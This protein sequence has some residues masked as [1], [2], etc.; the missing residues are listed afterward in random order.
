MKGFLVFRITIMAVMALLGFAL[1]SLLETERG[2]ISILWMGSLVLA[3]ALLGLALPP[4]ALFISRSLQQVPLHNLFAAILG[5]G[6]SLLLSALF[7]VPLSLLPGA[8]GKILPV[9]TTLVFCYV[10]TFLAVQRSRE[11][12]QLF[13][14]PYKSKAMRGLSAFNGGQ[15]LVDTS[16][17]IDGRIADISRTGF[18]RGEML[19]PS[20]VLAELQHIADSSD[21]LRRRRGRRGLDMLNK[22][23]KE[24]EVPV[25]IID[26]DFEDVEG[27][28]AKLVKL[29]KSLRCPIISNDFNLNRVAELQG[30]AV[31][32]INELAMSVKPIVLP[33]E[34]M[35]IRIIQEGKEAGQGV[36]FLDDGTMVVVEGGKRYIN[37]QVEVV[38]TRVL[39]T[40]VGRMVFAQIKNGASR[41]R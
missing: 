23:Q 18:L 8:W 14:S 1:A 26:M 33:G 12:A 41:E 35:G 40:A 6:V 28:D 25:Q 24:A 15:V 11:L 22:L 34:E 36:G 38:I 5:L 30:V 10:G 3:G 7:S 29:A 19:I 32:N 21:P 39:Q 20:F 13:P 16:T 27:V 37:N 31:L 2:L 17:I 4:F 9:P